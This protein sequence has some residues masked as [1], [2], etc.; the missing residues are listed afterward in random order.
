MHVGGDADGHRLASRDRAL[1]V[2]LNGVFGVIG[3]VGFFD[4]L[5]VVE[6]LYDA[7]AVGLASGGGAVAV[8]RAAGVDVD[9]GRQGEGEGRTLTLDAPDPNLTAMGRGDVLDDRQAEAGATGRAC[10]SGVD[11]V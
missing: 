2:G 6:G 7:W 1:V 5:G 10:P 9:P 3:G 11:P 4:V 8:H